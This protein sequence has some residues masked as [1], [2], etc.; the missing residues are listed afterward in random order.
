MRILVFNWLD[1]E[2]PQAGGAEF[3]LH[4]IFGRLTRWGHEVALLASGW[5]GAVPR[6]ELDGIEIHR[7]GARYTF[8][9]AAPRYYASVLRHRPFD[10]VVEDLNKVPLFTPLWVRRPLV[11]LVHHLFGGV[12]FQEA[13][14][15][16]A[17]ATWLLE[18]PIPR[19]YRKVPTVAISEST[20]DDLVRR[21]LSAAQIS[22][23][24]NG[25]ELAFY[26]VD[27]GAPRVP[28]PTVLYLGRLKRYKRID[29]ILRAAAHLRAEGLPLRVL[30]AGQGEEQAALARLRDR[31]GLRDTVEFLGF[32]SEEKKREL[33]RR[34]WVHVLTS[35]KEGWGITNVEAAA[36]AT[37]TVASDSP[38]LRESVVHG[39]T[40][41]LVPHGDVEALARRIGEVLRDPALRDRMGGAARRFAQRFSWDEAA[42]RVEERLERCLVR[43]PVVG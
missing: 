8:N 24:R 27:T 21:G 32:V 6:V 33:M 40:G 26:T 43:T 30:I 23:I 20:R 11:L 38:G 7:A 16:L 18:R 4:A 5:P 39:E 13:S 19:V 10:I 14:L 34:S 37:P 41:F 15:P 35:V 29:L 2:N 25:A 3:H 28:E 17:T 22:V 42:R 1:G 12:A 31:L 9:L 36:C